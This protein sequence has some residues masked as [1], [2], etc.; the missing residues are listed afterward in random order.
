M[1]LCSRWALQRDV[2]NVFFLP[3]KWKWSHYQNTS[4]A[5][6]FPSSLFFL[7]PTFYFSTFKISDRQ[8]V[9]YLT[10]TLRQTTHRNAVTLSQLVK[11]QS[12]SHQTRNCCLDCTSP[13]TKT[14]ICF[15]NERFS[16]WLH[17]VV[18]TVPAWTDIT[19]TI[20]QSVFIRSLVVA[21]SP[22]SQF[23]CAVTEFQPINLM[24]PGHH[25]P[26][27]LSSRWGMCVGWGWWITLC[28]AC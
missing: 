25:L 19:H 16:L 3:A 10:L 24:C 2:F 20:I 6:V 22:G 14:S 27:A 15:Q 9:K 13:E 17:F 8:R 28:H 4:H 18:L 5:H 21:D 26:P 1:K 11:P 7:T 12:L 23:D